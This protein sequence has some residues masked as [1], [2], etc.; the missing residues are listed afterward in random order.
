MVDPKALREPW[1]LSCFEKREL[2]NDGFPKTFLKILK[3]QMVI[4][5]AKQLQDP[6]VVFL[7]MLK[8]MQENGVRGVATEDMTVT[9]GTF[10]GCV[11]NMT[12]QLLTQFLQKEILGFEMGIKGG[13]AYVCPL[14]YIP[15]G[16]LRQTLFR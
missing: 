3:K 13:T 10:F 16:D 11:E 9:T 4:L 5:A 6:I 1:V 2:R 15:N 12:K 7:Q 8:K 14:D